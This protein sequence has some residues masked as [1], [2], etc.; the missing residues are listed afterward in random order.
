VDG[1]ISDTYYKTLLLLAV[2]CLLGILHGVTPANQL[3]VWAVLGSCVIGGWWAFSQSKVWFK[4]SLLVLFLLNLVALGLERSHSLLMT[5]VS[6]L[7][8]FVLI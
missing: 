3:R 5:V 8:V 2:M 1:Q 7:Y 4:A 6:M